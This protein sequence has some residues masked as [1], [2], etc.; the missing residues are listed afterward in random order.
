M[1]S[2]HGNIFIDLPLPSNPLYCHRSIFIVVYK[3][4]SIVLL[5]RTPPP[6]TYEVVSNIFWTGAAIYTALVVAR[7]TGI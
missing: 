3:D 5:A 2:S 7:S 6:S 4:A 1:P